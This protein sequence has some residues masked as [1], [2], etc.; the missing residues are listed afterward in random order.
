MHRTLLLTTLLAVSCGRPLNFSGAQAPVADTVTLSDEIVEAALSTKCLHKVSSD[1]QT[2][3]DAA[4]AFF[5]KRG[6][7]IVEEKT[8]QWA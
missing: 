3:L 1:P 6:V 8:G 7:K 2:N 4:L 5:K